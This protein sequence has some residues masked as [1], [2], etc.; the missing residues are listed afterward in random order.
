MQVYNLSQ[1]VQEDDLQHL[2][3]SPLVLLLHVTGVPALCSTRASCIV[4]ERHVWSHKGSLS[5]P[6]FT[7]AHE[8]GGTFAQD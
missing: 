1:N 3:V 7:S 8:H 2:Q 4:L 6:D 5:F